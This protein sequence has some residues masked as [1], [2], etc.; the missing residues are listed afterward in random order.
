MW[1]RL[2]L[3]P[4]IMTNFGTHRLHA[5]PVGQTVAQSVFSIISSLSGLA[6]ALYTIQVFSTSKICSPA[7]KLL[8][9]PIA[10]GATVGAA[11]VPSYACLWIEKYWYSLSSP[12]STSLIVKP[13]VQRLKIAQYA[14][15][16][17]LAGGAAVC[18]A[19]LCGNQWAHNLLES[20]EHV[21][22]NVSW[23]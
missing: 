15:A 6:S 14:L 19:A 3:V 18:V 11:L 8:L 22:I 23:Q 16:A 13:S 5:D 4:L 2:V 12:V 17:L 1:H 10:A 9:T 20:T 7:A 21:Y